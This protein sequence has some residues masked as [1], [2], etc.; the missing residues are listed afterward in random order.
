MNLKEWRREIDSI[1]EQLVALLEA[2]A[3]MAR[4][5]GALKAAA[6][7]PV[8][9]RAREAEILRNVLRRRK[10]ILKREAIIRIFRAVIGESRSVQAENP[11]P[12]SVG[13]ERLL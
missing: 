8:V 1:D 4:K 7:L 10:G 3:A 6:G 2:R 11:A 9:D 13:T 5:I 12:G